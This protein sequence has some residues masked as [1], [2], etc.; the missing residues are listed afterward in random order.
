MADA[1]YQKDDEI[2]F[3]LLALIWAHKLLIGLITGLSIFISGYHS[4][5][6]QKLYTLKAIFEIE[7]NNVG[8]GI[9][10]NNELGAWLQ[11]L[12]PWAATLVQVLRFYLSAL[13]EENLF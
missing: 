9:N 6:I 7:Q 4:L 11:S 10:I 1:D 2:D 13:W 12:G 8:R 5:T 3:L